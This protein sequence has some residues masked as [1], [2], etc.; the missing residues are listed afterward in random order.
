MGPRTMMKR[1]NCVKEP[2]AF[3][4][5]R[6]NISVNY[7]HEAHSP[8]CSAGVVGSNR[9][10]FGRLTQKPP[11]PIAVSWNPLTSIL[12]YLITYLVTHSMEQS[13]S[14]EANRFSASP[15]ILP[16]LGNTKVHYRIHKCTG[17]FTSNKITLA[18]IKYPRFN[19]RTWYAKGI[20]FVDEELD[21]GK[22][23]K[24]RGVPSNAGRSK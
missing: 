5:I 1:S 21:L 6:V 12:T 9:Q 11:T 20:S 8:L 22:T 24:R 7:S 23:E 18:N 15:E 19:K 4:K 2:I 17:N 16:I 13:P 3:R 14:W 10:A